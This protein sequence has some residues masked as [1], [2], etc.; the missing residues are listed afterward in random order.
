MDSSTRLPP[1]HLQ[2]I[3]QTQ[4]LLTTSV[5]PSLPKPMPLLTSMSAIAPF[6]SLLPHLFPS[7]YSL[8]SGKE[9][10]P[11]TCGSAHVILPLKTLQGFPIT[12]SKVFIHL[13]KN[14]DHLPLAVMD[15][16]TFPSAPA[17]CTPNLSPHCSLST[18]SI[19]PSI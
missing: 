1:C 12:N 6:V 14:L 11:I 13:P 4:T 5:L 16:T 10:D 7:N 9:G 15:F 8:T 19:L 17:H 3:S 18:Q 2:N